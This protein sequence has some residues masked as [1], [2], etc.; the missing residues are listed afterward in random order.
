ME[1]GVMAF[2]VME[3]HN[4]LMEFFKLVPLCQSLT[5]LDPRLR[6]DKPR[7]KKLGSTIQYLSLEGTIKITF[8]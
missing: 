8:G 3:F 1:F 6:S 7:S 5:K 4:P 2:G